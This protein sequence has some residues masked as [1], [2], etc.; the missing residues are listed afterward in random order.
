MTAAAAAAAAARFEYP[1]NYIYCNSAGDGQRGAMK[2]TLWERVNSGFCN[3]I[4]PETKYHDAKKIKFAAAGVE[5]GWEK[6]VTPA[7]GANGDSDILEQ[8]CQDSSRSMIVLV[9]CFDSSSLK[10]D[11][12]QYLGVQYN[13]H[14]SPKRIGAPDL[15]FHPGQTLTW[16][17]FPLQ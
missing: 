10:I 11:Q 9:L 7:A 8:I 12:L 13:D 14:P 4:I 16:T 1:A 5:G 15:P 3:M 17:L 6:C 2:R